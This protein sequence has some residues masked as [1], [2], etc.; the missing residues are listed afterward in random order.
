MRCPDC[1][2]LDSKVVDSRTTG[3]ATRRRRQ[4]SNCKSRFTTHERVERRILWV[5]KRSGDTEAWQAEKLLHGIALACRKRPISTAKMEQLV[6]D[7]EQTFESEHR[8]HTDAIGEAV[9]D[10]LAAV[11]PVATIR[12]A[13]VHRAF[14]NLDQF[15]EAIRPLQSTRGSK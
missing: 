13:S 11:D 3:D 14:E 10:L 9:I 4:C 6:K 5:D 1:Q 2:S 8:V 12:F 7:V 15:I